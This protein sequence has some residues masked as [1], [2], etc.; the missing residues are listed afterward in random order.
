MTMNKLEARYSV[1]LEYRRL[2]GEVAWWAFDSLKLRL[3]KDT[4]YETDFVVMLSDGTLEVHEVKGHWEDDARV[5]VKVAAS[6]FPFQ[7]FGVT[8]TS[9]TGTSDWTFESF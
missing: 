2:N 8:T 5:K 1:H 3:A 9:R 7:F 6:L 4:F